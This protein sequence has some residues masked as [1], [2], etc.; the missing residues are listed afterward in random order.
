MI[1]RDFRQRLVQDWLARAFGPVLDRH[2]DPRERARRVLEEALEFFQSV[3]GSKHEAYTLVDRT[4]GRPPGQPLEEL[5][6][7]G[8][9]LL[10]AGVGLGAS[11]DVQERMQLEAIMDKPPAYYTDRMSLK[12]LHHPAFYSEAE[13]QRAKSFLNRNETPK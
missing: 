10:A 9:T 3:E 6:Q 8:I 2:A 13:I 11:A 12:I 7:L 4:F 1:E 5:G